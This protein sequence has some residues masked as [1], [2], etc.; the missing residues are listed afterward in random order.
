MD[1]WVDGQIWTGMAPFAGHSDSNVVLEVAT[2]GRQPPR[3]PIPLI[4]KARTDQV[5]ALL[6]ACW[7]LNPGARPP[8]R[9]VLDNLQVL[10]E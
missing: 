7:N 6:Q 1:G 10:A 9:T 8:I 5:W 3:P 2:K 4:N